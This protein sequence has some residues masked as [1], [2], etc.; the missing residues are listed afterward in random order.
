MSIDVGT[1][2]AVL[3]VQAFFSYSHLKE[4]FLGLVLPYLF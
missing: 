4:W 2:E 3:G 1:A